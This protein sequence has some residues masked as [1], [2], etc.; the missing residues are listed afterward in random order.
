MC[1]KKKAK[2]LTRLLRV[3]SHII[4]SNG[5]G[6]M[7]KMAAL[8]IYEKNKNKNLLQNQITDGFETRYVELCIQV[9]PRLLNLQPWLT[10][11]F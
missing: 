10:L 7:T 8:P 4:Y 3:L 9:L 11:T 2:P 5:L 1:I 6:Q